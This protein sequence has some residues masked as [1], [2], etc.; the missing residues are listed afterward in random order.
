[1]LGRI[2]TYWDYLSWHRFFAS[3]NTRN[4]LLMSSLKSE[5]LSSYNLCCLSH[6]LV[7]HEKNEILIVA[8]FLRQ[9][10]HSCPPCISDASRHQRS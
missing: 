3:E 4:L 8:R 7:S 6:L 10:N 5:S 9:L 2:N 1:L